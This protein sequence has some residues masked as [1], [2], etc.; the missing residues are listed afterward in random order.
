[1]LIRSMGEMSIPGTKKQ[2]ANTCTPHFSAFPKAAQMFSE[3]IS[4]HHMD[5]VDWQIIKTSWL[6]SRMKFLNNN[7]RRICLTH[8]WAGCIQDRLGFSTVHCDLLKRL[9]A[10]LTQLFPVPDKL[11]QLAVCGVVTYDLDQLR[12]VVAV[13]LAEHKTRGGG[14]CCNQSWPKSQAEN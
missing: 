11:G 3:M 5:S 4:W 10:L 12:K 8:R 2:S 13:P 9:Q 14:S 6:P 7:N 1:M